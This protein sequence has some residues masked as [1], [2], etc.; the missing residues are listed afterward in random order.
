MNPHNRN[1]VVL[2]ICAGHWARRI[3]LGFGI[4]LGGRQRRE[5]AGGH[6]EKRRC[7]VW[8]LHS[9]TER[10]D[11]MTRLRKTTSLVAAKEAIEKI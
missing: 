7:I 4:S 8:Y 9:C 6:A 5:D 10:R 2:L 1:T 11:G 3:G